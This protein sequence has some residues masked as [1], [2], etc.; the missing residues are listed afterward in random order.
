MGEKWSS[1][2]FSGG[3]DKKRR[4]LKTTAAMKIANMM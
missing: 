3:F 4:S 2:E 1:K